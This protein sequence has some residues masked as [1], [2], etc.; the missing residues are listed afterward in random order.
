MDKDVNNQQGL[1]ELR[2]STGEARLVGQNGSGGL[3]VGLCPSDDLS[4]LYGSQPL[5]LLRIKVNGSGYSSVGGVGTEGL[6]FDGET[7]Y[8]AFNSTFFTVDPLTG[9]PRLFLPPPGGDAEGLAY[10]PEGHAVYGL[11]AGSGT[12]K[13]FDIDLSEWSTVGSTGIAFDN[14]GL[15]YDPGTGALYAKRQNDVNLYRIDPADASTEVVGSTGLTA[16][17]GL[18]FLPD[19]GTCHYVFKKV[20]AKRKCKHCPE[21]RTEYDHPQSPCGD[22]DECSKRFR[23][24]WD[25]LE[26]AKGTCKI[27]GKR[28]ACESW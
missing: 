27:F 20:K 5:G 16:G 28:T 4:I 14:H 13:K 9:Q 23:A 12:L 1:R 7:L 18:A 22:L 8:G 2:A 11:L 15:A 25:C 17:G 21:V 10:S 19:V 26:G 24:T 3:N 6:A